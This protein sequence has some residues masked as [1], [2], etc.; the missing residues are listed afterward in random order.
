MK[1]LL[2]FLLLC[3]S[4]TA[5]ACTKDTASTP[6]KWSFGAILANQSFHPETGTDVHLFP[7]FIVRRSFDA[8]TLRTALE[9][10]YHS[11]HSGGAPYPDATYS[12]GQSWDATLR[13]GIEKGWKTG[14]FIRPYFAADLGLSAY[15][16]DDRVIG[17]LAGYTQ[18][19]K[20][21][22]RSAGFMPAAGI[23]CCFGKHVGLA[24]ET[25]AALM[26]EKSTSQ[27]IYYTG[28][29]DTRPQTE[30]GFFAYFN[31]PA[32]LTLDFWF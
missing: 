21:D 4:L 29:V 23:E 22:R 2:F 32:S 30:S 3:A 6:G 8:F 16:T 18:E 11:Q 20:Y 5:G 1:R 27:L 14:R 7:G 28:N 24:V 19:Q 25:Q 12:V 17:G 13:F 15:G 31:H 10:A 9:G 26:Y